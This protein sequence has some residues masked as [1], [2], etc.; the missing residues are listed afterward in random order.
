LSRHRKNPSLYG[1]R[2][3]PES[4]LMRLRI[5]GYQFLLP[6]GRKQIQEWWQRTRQRQK[7]S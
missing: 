6:T 5:E 7:D 1:L 3:V 4:I 2:S